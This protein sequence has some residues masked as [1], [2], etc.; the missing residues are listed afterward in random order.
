MVLVSRTVIQK[1][2]FVE[3]APTDDTITVFA[4]EL[5]LDLAIAKVG[6]GI[7]VVED[8]RKGQ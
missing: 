5:R 8:F 3:N 4:Q 7:H 2:P 1:P 6:L